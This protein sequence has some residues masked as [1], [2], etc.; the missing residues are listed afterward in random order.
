M[1]RPLT[2]TL[3]SCLFIAAGV[4][5]IV[6][7]ASEWKTLGM[8]AETIWAFVIRALAIVGG[9]FTMRGSNFARWVLV[10]WIVY[11]VVLSFYHTT[12]ELV[13]HIAFAIVVLLGLFNSKANLYFK[14]R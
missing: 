11:H 5:G 7:H 3:I 13:T 12:A 6:Y 10:L 1:K 9:I 4:T 2:V 14:K 8:Q